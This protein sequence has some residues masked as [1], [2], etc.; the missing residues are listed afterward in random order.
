MN[1]HLAAS[2][3]SQ[4]YRV[5]LEA[6]AY[7]LLQDGAYDEAAKVFEVMIATLPNADHGHVGLAWIAESQWKWRLA[8]ER[9][10]RCL[11]VAPD[12]QR[13]Q[14]TARKAH[15]LVRI[16]QIKKATE[17][18]TSISDS[19][20]GLE[21]LAHVATL[22]ESRSVARRCWEKCMS[23]FPDQVGGFLGM[24]RLLCDCD[25]Y[26]EAQE[27]LSH[28]IAV[29]PES[30][31]AGML[32]ARCATAMKDWETAG[33][34]W[35]VLLAGDGSNN[36]EVRIGYSRYLAAQG[37]AGKIDSYLQTP[38]ADPIAKNECLL[39]FHLARD[40]YGPVVECARKLVKLEPQKPWRR[41]Q[42]ATLLIRHGSL[43]ELRTAVKVLGDLYSES[44]ESVEIKAHLIEG[45]IRLGLERQ[46]N[47]LLESIPFDEKRIG[48]EQL[49]AWAFHQGNDDRGAKRCWERLLQR[50]Y[51]QAIHGRVRNLIRI[52]ESDVSI[53]PEDIVLFS[54]MRNEE[55]RLNRFL[56]HYRNLGVDRFV[57]LDNMSTDNTARALL[58]NNDVVLYQTSDH[59]SMSSCGA[60]W[61]NELISRHGKK[62]WCLFVDADESLMFPECENLTLHALTDYLNENDYEAMMAPLLDMYPAKLSVGNVQGHVADRLDDYSFFDNE[63]HVCAHLICPYKEIFGGVRRRLFNLYNLS[64]KAP[65]INGAAGVKFIL[66]THQITPAKMADVSGTLLHYHLFYLLEGKYR[67]LFSNAIAHRE[68]PSNSLERLRSRDLLPNVAALPS[69][70]Y[71]SSIQLKSSNQLVDLG[72]MQ[73]SENFLKWRSRQLKSPRDQGASF[74]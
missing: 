19:I 9:W 45:Y 22:E 23:E 39:E 49:R 48:I 46:A 62:N 20:A 3:I 17:L 38:S 54:V 14:A 1:N 68:F 4:A 32:L 56:K 36:K 70:L 59:F 16:G 37:D 12:R 31:A 57:I 47:E 28:I 6:Q 63:R 8:I 58:G 24:A 2:P 29:W 33:I 10:D 18:F 60:R 30:I 7:A 5:D 61:V 53:R 25:D 21:G 27:L 65:L 71:E 42:Y 66:T 52:D 64:N 51:M 69:L 67:A 55:P 26:E 44:S 41:L 34:Q 74:G 15:C 50:H 72:L 43:N 13:I 40:D 73:T 35:D 11:K